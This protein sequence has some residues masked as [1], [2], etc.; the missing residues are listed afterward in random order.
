[1]CS[2]MSHSMIF[3]SY[4][5]L[6]IKRKKN[7][8]VSPCANAV[9]SISKGSSKCASKFKH[10]AI[11]TRFSDPDP[12]FAKWDSNLQSKNDF[13]AVRIHRADSIH[14]AIIVHELKPDLSR[15]QQQTCE[16]KR[17]TSML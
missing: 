7:V 5:C 1:M 3:Q 17:L 2:L 9:T 11:F 10:R 16:C 15:L 8:E 4:V 14:Y 12:S 13:Y 6:H